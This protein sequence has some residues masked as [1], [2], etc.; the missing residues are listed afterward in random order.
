M[1]ERERTVKIF[2]LG[3]EPREKDYWLTRPMEE[4]VME[5]FRLRAMWGADDQPMQRVVSVRPL[6]RK[7]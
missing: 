2:A 6:K 5:V 4:R 1:T 3:A 7:A